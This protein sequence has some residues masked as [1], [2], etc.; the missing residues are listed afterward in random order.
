MWRWVE[1]DVWAAILPVQSWDCE[2][3]SAT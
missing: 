3:N 2:L 1:D